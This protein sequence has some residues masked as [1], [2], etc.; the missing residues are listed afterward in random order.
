MSLNLKMLGIFR[1]DIPDWIGIAVLE[2]WCVY[3]C[4]IGILSALH[5]ANK[6]GGCDN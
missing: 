5:F 4:P 3:F 6:E 1:T 2:F